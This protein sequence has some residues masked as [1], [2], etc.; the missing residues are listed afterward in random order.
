M[1]S[2]ID[3]GKSG[4]SSLSGGYS[5]RHGVG[6]YKKAIQV[7]TGLLLVITCLFVSVVCLGDD[8]S[9]TA[10][11]NVVAMGIEGDVQTLNAWTGEIVGSFST[12]GS[13]VRSTAI[14]GTN[15][16]P[17][18]DVDGHLWT[19][20]DGEVIKFPPSVA[21]IV[22]ESH[23]DCVSVGEDGT[24]RASEGC[25][26]LIGDKTTSVWRVNME[27]G[28]GTRLGRSR[29]IGNFDGEQQADAGFSDAASVKEEFVLLQRNDYVV[30]ALRTS[31]SLEMWNVAVSNFQAIDLDESRQELRRSDDDSTCSSGPSVLVQPDGDTT[32][33]GKPALIHKFPYMLYDG[34][35]GKKISAVHPQT[36]RVLWSQDVNSTVTSLFGVAKGKW[37]DLHLATFDFGTDAVASNLSLVQ[38][39]KKGP[40]LYLSPLAST[41]S[42][43]NVPRSSPWS[44]L[45]LSH[46][47][48][49]LTDLQQLK[50][51]ESRNYRLKERCTGQE[52][53]QLWLPGPNL[54]SN[55]PMNHGQEPWLTWGQAMML[56][57][58]FVITM[59]LT[60]LVAY[61]YGWQDAGTSSQNPPGHDILSDAV[62]MDIAP[63]RM[64]RV[65]S[66]PAI[67]PLKSNLC[68]SKSLALSQNLRPFTSFR[69][70]KGQSSLFGSNSL[71]PPKKYSPI[72]TAFS[73]PISR[74]SSVDGQQKN[75]NS[76]IPS[77]D[78]EGDGKKPHTIAEEAIYLSV[79]T[80]EGKEEDVVLLSTRGRYA[81]EF[82]EKGRLGKG[83]FGAVYKSVN[84]LDGHDYAIK[85]I[86]LS[87]DV[88][89]RRQLERVLREVKIIAFL[90]HP[91]I[92]RYYQAWLE[93][94]PDNEDAMVDEDNYSLGDEK[95]TSHVTSSSQRRRGMSAPG[96]TISAM[97]DDSTYSFCSIHSEESCTSA[98]SASIPGFIFE[99][100]ATSDNNLSTSGMEDASGQPIWRQLAEGHPC[101][102]RS[103]PRSM[104]QFSRKTPRQRRLQGRPP[105]IE[106]DLILFIQM[107]Y[108]SEQTLL[109]HLQERSGT[110]NIA[111][112]LH[113]F[114]QICR[115]IKYVHSMKLI[116]R[117]LKPGNIL[118]PEENVKI[119]DFGLSRY[120]LDK[121]LRGLVKQ[122]SIKHSLLKR[123]GE[124]VKNLSTD[125][126]SLDIT[127]GV[128]TYL[129]MAP[130]ITSGGIY[131]QKAD[132]FSLG[133]ILLEASCAFQTVMERVVVLTNARK[134]CS[135]P[136]DYVNP[137]MHDLLLG[138]L[139]LN[140]LNRPTAADVVERIEAMQ[141]MHMVLHL[142]HQGSSEHDATSMVLRIEAMEKEGLLHELVEKVRGSCASTPSARLLQ[143]GVRGTSA[144][145]I[146]EFHIRGTGCFDRGRIIQELSGLKDVKT[147]VDVKTSC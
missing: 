121:E 30:R 29:A 131:D 142:G 72:S 27:T 93:Y 90:D 66:L 104:H 73:S 54:D 114:M 81:L 146:I 92:V 18:V 79:P 74:P 128:G 10:R 101:T 144:G 4:S 21:D 15:Q 111:Q 70:I 116:H 132:I 126:S 113:I 63:E 77:T 119:G 94:A 102:S 83:G 53:R 7:F 58:V 17:I 6:G 65:A 75:A 49:N 141:G 91:N 107:Q 51:V 143:Y 52:S 12:G 85:K 88:R 34:V 137:D 96:D 87:S 145:S 130:E 82:L 56:V 117:D 71:S 31:S 8:S 89:N 127:D 68:T 3:L 64:Q 50:G 67:T 43:C 44:S 23:V 69:Q 13:L 48:P 98:M 139:Q 5:S 46:L 124:G 47:P 59:V 99:R 25:G 28:K 2:W 1:S 108:C 22:A 57:S 136:K 129:Y 95:I 120:V 39:E 35:S 105:P 41:K 125:A 60:A 118:L 97:D 62:K 106:D 110:V 9:G 140:P 14:A 115:G 84:R 78:M 122:Q 42:N 33:S 38:L 37:V 11:Y 26:L 103:S 45:Q 133:V 86:Y 19:N 138:M 147:V 20:N 135:I 76:A 123:G 61:R 109:S 40:R 32:T 24:M 16:P 112:V 80:G 36:G 55:E 134:S 100:E